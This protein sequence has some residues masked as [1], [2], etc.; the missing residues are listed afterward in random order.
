M[1][2][3]I[4]TRGLRKRYGRTRAL[5]GLDLSVE[6]GRIHGLLAI[7]GSGG[8]SGFSSGSFGGGSGGG[9]TSMSSW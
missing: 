8:S 6:A 9:G 4:H 5:D 3:V 1:S 2:D 7:G